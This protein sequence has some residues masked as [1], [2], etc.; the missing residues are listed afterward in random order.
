MSDTILTLNPREFGRIPL[1]DA[2]SIFDV[3]GPGA[4]DFLQ[5]MVVN[6]MNVKVGRSV[7]TPL[8]NPHGGFKAI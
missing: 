5:M 8:L 2:V 3:E 4:L 7:Y 6:Q 1:F